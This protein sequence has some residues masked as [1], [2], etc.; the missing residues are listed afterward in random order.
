MMKMY[1][2]VS[3]GK[4]VKTKIDTWAIENENSK[5]GDKSDVAVE[6]KQLSVK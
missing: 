6:E 1:I 4:G 5:T 3:Q 2:R